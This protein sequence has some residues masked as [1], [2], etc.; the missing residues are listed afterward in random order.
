MGYR[1]MQRL[2]VQHDQAKAS[3]A[4]P[5]TRYVPRTVHKSFSQAHDK[6]A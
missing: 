4:V 5:L 3:M 2:E 1:S 6:Y